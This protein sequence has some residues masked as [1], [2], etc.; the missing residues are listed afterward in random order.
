MAPQC[1]ARSPSSTLK[2]T[3]KLSIDEPALGRPVGGAPR[4]SP[5]LGAAGQGP[6]HH[7]VALGHLVRHLQ[8]QL[9]GG[10]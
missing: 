3:L 4:D 9:G 2:L 5:G 1:S 10:P 7:A 8:V 6:R